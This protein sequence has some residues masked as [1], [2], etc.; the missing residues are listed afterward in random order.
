MSVCVCACTPV[1]AASWLLRY[2]RR[3]CS[4][5]YFKVFL[6]KLFWL[7]FIPSV[8]PTGAGKPQPRSP[9]STPLFVERVQALPSE[10][11]GADLHALSILIAHFQSK[12]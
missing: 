12:C 7:S 10:R 6:K 2:V 9:L 4:V 5:C 11:L 8:Q 1:H 3:K